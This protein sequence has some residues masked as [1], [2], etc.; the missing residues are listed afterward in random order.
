MICRND[1][2]VSVAVFACVLSTG[3]KYTC[4]QLT[5]FDVRIES[6]FHFLKKDIT[7]FRSD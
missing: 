2:Y 5:L 3:F 6:L 1:F 4:W 7:G